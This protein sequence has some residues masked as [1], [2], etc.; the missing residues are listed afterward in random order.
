MACSCIRSVGKDQRIGLLLLRVHIQQ[1]YLGVHRD[2][3]AGHCFGWNHL[4]P[5]EFHLQTSQV[6]TSTKAGIGSFLNQF[7]QAIEIELGDLNGFA[8]HRVYS[9][10]FCPLN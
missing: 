4:R 1:N 7:L 5:L 9:Q 10:K 6:V 2:D 3:V 8:D